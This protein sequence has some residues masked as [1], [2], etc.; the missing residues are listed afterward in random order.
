M[1]HR[2]AKLSTVR[3]KI[4]AWLPLPLQHAFDRS[5]AIHFASAS[6]VCVYNCIAVQ[7]RFND[8]LRGTY[9]LAMIILV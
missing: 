9:V 6:P 3:K 7:Y 8:R 4:V 1:I 2:L 5:M